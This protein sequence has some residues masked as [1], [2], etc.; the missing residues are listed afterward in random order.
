MGHASHD[1]GAAP[2]PTL[3]IA[4]IFR[5]HGEDAH[6]RF[7]FSPEQRL[8]MRHIIECRTAALGGH[9]ER[10]SCCEFHRP[11]YNSCRDR[12][13]P[14]CQAT[15]QAQWL[16][17]RL[18]RVLPV[19]HYHIVFT[20]PG[21]L[22]PLAKRLPRTVYEILF[23][24]ASKTLIEF[25]T[26]P[27][28]LGAQLGIT[29]VLH[30]WTR[31]LRQHPHLHCIVTAGGLDKDAQSWIR[32]RHAKILFP[33]HALAK[34]FRG[35]VLDAIANLEM[36]ERQTANL[37]DDDV[38][39]RLVDRLYRSR[40][41]VYAKRPFA[42]TE[43][44]FAYLGR[45]THRVAISNHRII[46]IDDHTVHFATKD[47]KSQRL[48]CHEFIRRFLDHVLPNHFTKIRHYGILGN[49]RRTK[50]VPLAR[51]ALENSRWRME[52][53]PVKP[54]PTPERDASTCPHCGSKNLVC[55]GRLAAA[56]HYTSLRRATSHLI[57]EAVW[58]P[59]LSDSS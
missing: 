24:A 45:Y 27:K 40:W 31:D 5:R 23:K 22:R 16:E 43:H 13:C 12:H 17:L 55:V 44:V 39:K 1:G 11:A 33:V 41:V 52:L 2:R 42:T 3:D 26:D 46:A 7:K 10:C 18:E 9:L 19:P 32:P 47:G 54:L 8:V 57:L 15:R 4:D 29:A 53:A 49:N 25:G 21:L 35:K 38:L 14:K 51:Q 20:L 48:P 28:W 37:V 6:A 36:P 50:L 30:T 58:P 59:K 56:G 34:A